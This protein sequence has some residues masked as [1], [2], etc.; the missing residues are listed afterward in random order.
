MDFAEELKTSKANKR[1]EA[2]R[3]DQI[4][5]PVMTGVPWYANLIEASILASSSFR[6]RLNYGCKSSTPLP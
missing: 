3:K 6:S 2:I 1:E 4:T 5:A